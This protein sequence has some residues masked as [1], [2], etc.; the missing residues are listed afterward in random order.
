M[1]L[2]PFDYVD[3][4]C[5]EQF[6]CFCHDLSAQTRLCIAAAVRFDE[7]DRRQ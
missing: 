5:S 1:V 3:T 2:T 6:C 4:T 7:I